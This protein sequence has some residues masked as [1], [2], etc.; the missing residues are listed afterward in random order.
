MSALLNAGMPVASSC[1][2][3]GVCGKCRLQIIKG[4]ENLSAINETE[5]FLRE[6][7]QLAANERISCQTYVNGDI[8]VDA[9]YW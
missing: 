2:G 3:D 6:R 4:Q 5:Q 9:T 1:F 8:T 7:Y